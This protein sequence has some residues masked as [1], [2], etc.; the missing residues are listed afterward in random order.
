MNKKIRF[1]LLTLLV[2]LCGTVFAEDTVK[3][4]VFKD[5]GSDSDSSN[6]V[7]DISGIISEGAEFVSAIPT[8]T[9]VY[10]GRSGRGLKLG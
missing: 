8:A 4:I 10:N 1:S 2:M 9:N 6:K 7:T 3:S 5:T